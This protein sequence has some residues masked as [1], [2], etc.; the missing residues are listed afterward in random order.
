MKKLILLR[1]FLLPVT[2]IFFFNSCVN[3]TENKSIIAGADPG[4]M[5]IGWASANITPDKPVLLI[6]QWQARISE[7]VMDSITVTALAIESGTG[8]SSEKAILISCDLVCIAEASG[9]KNDYMEKVR[10]LLKVSLP[11]LRPEQIII[12]ATHTHTA[13]LGSNAA[14]KDLVGIELNVMPPAD[15]LEFSCRRIASA[16]VMAWKSR[17]Q[18]GISFGLGHAVVG[19]NRLAAYMSGKSEMYGNTNTPEFSHL[20]GYE[21]HSVNLLYTWDNKSTLTGM[22]INIP[23]P[24][25]VS[26]NE[27]FISADYWHDTRSEI[28]K[29]LGRNVFI[30]AQ[31]SAAG[32]QSPHLMVGKKAEERMERLMWPDSTNSGSANIG[33]RKQIAVSIADAAT[34][35]L[36][37]T[38]ANIDWKPVFYNRME[39]IDLPRL[40][41]SGQN[42]KNLSKET[43]EWEK[44]YERLFR[45]IRENPALKSKPGWYTEITQSYAMITSQQSVMERYELQKREPVLPVEIHVIRLGDIVMATN[46]FELYLDYGMRIKA[47]SP[48]VQTFIVQLS[49]G[50][51]GYL[52]TKRSEAGGAYGSDPVEAFIGPEGGQQLVEKTLELIDTLWL[53]K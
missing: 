20:E 3:R 27:Y 26:E 11:E 53:K 6:G 37:Y 5:K 2:I 30:L 14:V 47:R 23:C 12:N 42:V 32:D 17:K 33:Q 34:A 19:H 16:A 28:R 21:D 29:R 10:E 31:C 18:G 45:E 48:A 46:P 41:I 43:D 13:P 39:T 22:I 24:S 44:S 1:S 36:Q 4:N 7:G 51:D 8:A 52:P 35:V 25:Q 9:F 40:L 15:Y 50:Y 49:N 38:K